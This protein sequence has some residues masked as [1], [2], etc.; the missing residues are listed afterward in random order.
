MC[1]DWV[2]HKRRTAR[3]FIKMCVMIIQKT[4]I[5]TFRVAGQKKVPRPS[6]I[7]MATT[8]EI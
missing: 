1:N 7:I 5:L 2:L 6:L 3:S 8:A 4:E